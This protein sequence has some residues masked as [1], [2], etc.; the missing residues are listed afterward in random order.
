MRTV[1]IPGQFFS[2]NIDISSFNAFARVRLLKGR[3]MPWE[4]YKDMSEKD[5]K[6]LYNYF[7]SLEPVRN[8]IGATY[9]VYAKK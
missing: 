8:N 6:A 4:G 2:R 7:N 5:L 9:E 1:V 3:P